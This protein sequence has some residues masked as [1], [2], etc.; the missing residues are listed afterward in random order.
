MKGQFFCPFEELKLV[1]SGNNLT[2]SR[3]GVHLSRKIED[4]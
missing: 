2:E 1:I 4:H 3:T